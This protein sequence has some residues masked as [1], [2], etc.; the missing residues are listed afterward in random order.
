MPQKHSCGIIT[1]EDKKSGVQLK[2]SANKRGFEDMENYFLKIIE[3]FGVNNQQRKLQEEIFELQEAITIHE[4][5]KTVE[6]EVPLFEI[7]G[8]R[9]DIIEEMADVF[10]LLGQFKSYFDVS[11]E[12]L[13]K[14]ILKKIN[15]TLDRI[16]SGYYEK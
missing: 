14:N 11:D 5:K 2:F 15:R 1:F 3:H 9:E 7:V 10:I 12:E 6:Y 4:F 16:G 8:T 13:E